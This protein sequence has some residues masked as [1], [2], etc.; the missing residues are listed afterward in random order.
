MSL[1]LAVRPS[2]H[3][4]QFLSHWTDFREI[5]YLSIFQKPVEKIQAS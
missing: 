1:H 3:M 2:V 4:E 5:W